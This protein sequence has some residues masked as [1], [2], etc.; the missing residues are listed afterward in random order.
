MTAA[1]CPEK[2]KAL[3]IED[4][5]LTLDNYQSLI[6]SSLDMFGLWLDLKKS[7][8]SETE[9]SMALAKKYKDYPGVTSTGIMFFARCLW[10]L[11]PNF[12]N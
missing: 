11:D 1:R 6:D 10:Q 9:L 2:V 4:A 12:L 5:P 8:Q 3:I 7:P